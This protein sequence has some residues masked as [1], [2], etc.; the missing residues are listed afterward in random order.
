MKRPARLA[1]VSLAG[2]AALI[3]SACSGS[4]SGTATDD[5]GPIRVVASTNVYGDLVSSVGGA[6]VDVTS[7]IDSPDKDPHEYEADARTQLAVSKAQLIVENGGGYDDFIGT[8]VDA[9]KSTAPVINA[10]DVSGY[11]QEGEFNEHVWYD[12]PTVTAV[13]ADIASELSTID[14]ANAERYTQNADELTQSIASLSTRVQELRGSVAGTGIAITEP[15]PLYLLEALGL[16][17]KTP[18]AFSEA[19]EEDSDVAASVL[20]ETLALFEQ[21]QVAALVY[22][23]QTTGA[24]TDAVLDAA[25]KAGIPAVPV[26]ETLPADLHYV[27][28]M[29]ANLDAITEALGR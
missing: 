23:E 26:T 2:A 11:D 16:D 17:N 13:V 28:W 8:M 19:V 4:T 18:E 10:S 27:D 1:L 6:L 7:V 21:R 15:V 9:S 3:L 12:L 24:Q 29:N 20:E 14:P 22:N 5:S 25:K